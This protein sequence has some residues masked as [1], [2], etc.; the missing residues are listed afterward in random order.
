MSYTFSLFFFMSSPPSNGTTL[1][2]SSPLAAAG[3]AE[4]NGH[5]S[6]TNSSGADISSRISSHS[7]DFI[8][9]TPYMRPHTDGGGGGAV[10]ESA[11][12][13]YQL[14]K[15]DL[16]TQRSNAETERRLKLAQFFLTLSHL[17]HTHANTHIYHNA[18]SLCGHIEVLSLK[19]TLAML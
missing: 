5:H 8:I 16:H 11:T 2:L 19:S 1:A 13:P 7:D 14:Y 18:Y 9:S 12:E 6:V 17:T 3:E 4:Q 10:V 15:Q